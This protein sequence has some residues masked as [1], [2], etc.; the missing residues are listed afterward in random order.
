MAANSALVV[1]DLDFDTLKSSLQTFLQSQTAFKDYDFSGS[2]LNVLL[3]VLAYNTQQGAFYLNM[4]SAEAYLDS[5]QL[6]D[7][8]VSHAKELNYLPASTKSPLAV[9]NV[10]FATAGITG[11][12]TMPRGTAFSSI[13][14]N[15]TYQFVTNAA[16]SVVSGNSTFKFAN[17]QLFEGTFVNETWVFTGNAIPQHYLSLIHI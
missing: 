11:A 5:A 8:V 1:V 12:F 10:S 16:L 3:D 17:V 7:S 6:I 13:N 4:V 2:N 9:V 15:G 14:A